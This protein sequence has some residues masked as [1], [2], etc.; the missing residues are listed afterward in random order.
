MSRIYF[1]LVFFVLYLVWDAAG[2]YADAEFDY[3]QRPRP[4]VRIIRWVLR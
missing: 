4:G 1:V 2:G 3:C